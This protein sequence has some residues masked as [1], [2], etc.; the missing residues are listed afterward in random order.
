MASSFYKAA[1]AVT[2][3]LSSPFN[4]LAVIYK[5]QVFAELHFY[6][7]TCVYFLFPVAELQMC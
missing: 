3:A 4:N 5:Q 1:I 2:T 6:F 7:H